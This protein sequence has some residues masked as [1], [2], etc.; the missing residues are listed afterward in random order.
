M[1]EFNEHGSTVILYLLSGKFL[2]QKQ[3]Y[4]ES[5]TEDK[6]FC[7]SMGGSFG[8]DMDLRFLYS[9]SRVSVY[10][11]KS[12]VLLFLQWKLSNV[13]DQLGGPVLF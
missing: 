12:K 10:S 13:A 3:C 2:A 7:R 5:L 9:L 6:A 11:S 8:R 4:V 1:G